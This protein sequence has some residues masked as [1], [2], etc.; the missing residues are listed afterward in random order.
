V[1]LAAPGMDVNQADEN[2]RTPLFLAIA[3][4]HLE[5]VKVLL[6]VPGIDVNLADEDGETPL[7][8]ARAARA[9]EIVALLEAVGAPSGSTVYDAALEGNAGEMKQLLA[10]PGIDVNRANKWGETPLR[11][12]IEEG[13]L[14]M[15]KLLLAA[16]GIDVNRAD[17]HGITPLHI[18]SYHGHSEVVK[19]LLAAPEI[20]VNRADKWGET[21]LM[22]AS[23]QGKSEVVK[24][25]LAAPGIRVLHRDKREKSATDVAVTSE[26]ANLLDEVVTVKRTFG[27]LL[28][29]LAHC[30][31]S[32][33]MAA[34]LAMH[35]LPSEEAKAMAVRMRDTWPAA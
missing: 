16:P 1:L 13:H 33:D 6:A 31:I 7:H 34:L 10:A 17:E 24:L 20:D 2:G 25:L 35:G 32:R 14:E 3:E 23:N 21:P 12:A 29:T 15:V 9:W 18:A 22:V 27:R 26:V 19:L 4:G 11:L 30:G 28:L 5:L 8:A